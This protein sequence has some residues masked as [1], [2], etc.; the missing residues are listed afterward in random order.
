MEHEGVVVLEHEVEKGGLAGYGE[1]ETVILGGSLEAVSQLEAV[2]TEHLG[3]VELLHLLDTGETCREG[4]RAHP[5]AAGVGKAADSALEPLFTAECG[6][7]PAVCKSLAE[8]DKVGLEAVEVVGACDIKTEARSD[9][10]DDKDDALLGAELADLLPIALCGEDVVYEIAVKVGSGDERCDLALVL[11]NYSLEALKIVPVNIEVVGDI[12]GKNAGVV[13]LLAPGSDAVIE[14]VDEDYLLPVGG[15]SGGHD[16]CGG[17][18][19]AV[20]CEESPVSRSDGVDKALRELDYLGRGRGDAVLYLSLC[21][22]CGVNIGV[23]VAEHV[24]AV[25]AHI[26]DEFVAVDIPEVGA[27]SLLAEEGICRYG[28]AAALSG[29]LMAVKTGGDYLSGSLK[30]LGAFIIFI[31]FET[32]FAN[33]LMLNRQLLCQGSC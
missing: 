23:I 33:L 29:A 27:L 20:L 25:S 10:V 26:V 6:D 7:V 18:V 13:D 5:I 15:C 32:H 31:Y 2:L 24:G 16:S 21:K 9:V 28:D 19:A 12:L 1:M 30:E 4:D 22:S 8:A 14:A 17:G 3:S 11:L